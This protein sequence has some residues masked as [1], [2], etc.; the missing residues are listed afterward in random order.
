MQAFL[1]IAPP[2]STSR[3]TRLTTDTDDV[4]AHERISIFRVRGTRACLGA[5]DVRLEQARAL[6]A[7]GEAAVKGVLERVQLV[8]ELHLPLV[9]CLL[10]RVALFA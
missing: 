8:L 6:A 7:A 3:P 4:V 5:H 2:D 9:Q 1:V 10:L